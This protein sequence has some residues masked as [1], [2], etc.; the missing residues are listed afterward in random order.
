MRDGVKLFT[1][2]YAP[3]DSSQ[4]FPILINRTPY[5][6]APYGPAADRQTLG[7]SP[8]FA[9]EGY[10]F[11][12]QDVRGR[13]MSEG[14]F[15]WMTPYKEKKSGPKDVDEST[16]TYDTIDWLLKN[17]PNNNGRVGIYGIS[18]PGFYAASALIDPH[19]ALKAVSPQAPMADN[20]LGDDIHHN[21]AF[22]LPHILTFINFFG[23]PRSGPTETYPPGVQFGPQNG[24]DF[25]LQMG[26]L[27][28]VNS[29]YFHG[30]VPIWDE[31]LA[32]GDYDSYWQAQDVPQHLKKTTPAVM[33]VG[34]WFDAEDLQ[35]TLRIYRALEKYNPQ[36][37]NVLVM[38]PWSHG[39]WAGTNG[40]SL[41][42]V[43]F[44]SNTAAFYRASMELPFF[45]YYLKGK[46]NLSL[47]EASVFETGTNQWKTYDH[48][49]PAN[50]RQEN[51]YLE[52]DGRLAFSPPA[53]SSSK[54]YDEYVS[55]PSE[56][57]AVYRTGPDRHG[58]GVH[59]RR[60]AFC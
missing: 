60:S 52:P 41:G 11:V 58:P 53:N 12:F 14:D 27:R 23:R 31:W 26:P 25:F 7:P 3:D 42:D 38:G 35:G 2:V 48:W 22:W 8:A 17:I 37:F 34:G 36:N 54:T 57:R 18:Y 19:P 46:G 45:N 6:V 24:Y 21:G 59:G 10:I 32:H 33:T 4:K 51:L 44:G 39:G 50:T 40:R 56:S 28:N 49:P 43:D 29:K 47:P 30:E 20:Y 15:K 5:S 9:E 1:S 13:F 55:D 16:D